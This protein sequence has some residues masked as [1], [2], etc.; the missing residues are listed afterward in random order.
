MSI[1]NNAGFIIRSLMTPF[2]MP[3]MIHYI[4][5]QGHFDF[6]ARMRLVWTKRRGDAPRMVPQVDLY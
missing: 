1:T 5:D 3:F 6:G 4:D 2:M